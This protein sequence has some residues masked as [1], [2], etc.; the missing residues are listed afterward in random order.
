MTRIKW[1]SRRWIIA[2]WAMLSATLLMVWSVWTQYSPDWLGV[3]L[4][5]LIGI[6][7]GYIAA[8]S[9]TKPRGQ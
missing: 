2:V 5:I 9:M 3:V 6:A 7:G 1:Q 8:D 4:P